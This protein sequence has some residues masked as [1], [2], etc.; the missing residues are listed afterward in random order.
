MVKGMVL[1]PVFCRLSFFQAVL[2]TA[3]LRRKVDSHKPCSADKQSPPPRTP[4]PECTITQSPSLTSELG[5]MVVCSV[6]LDKCI[7]P[8]IDLTLWY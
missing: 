3:E 4:L 1:G 2:F 7:M 6:D 5:L 8:Q